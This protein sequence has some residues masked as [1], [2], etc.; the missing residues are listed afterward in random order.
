MPKTPTETASAK[1]SLFS[2]DG[3]DRLVRATDA[4]GN[5]SQTTYDVAGNA[6]RV[7][8]WGHPPN[9]PGAPNVL[10][11]HRSLLHDELGRVF[12][13]DVPLFVSQGFT[14]ARPPLLQDHDN[15]GFVTTRMDYDAL[16]RVTSLVED[17]LQTSRRVYDG[18]GRVIETM[19]QV[20]NRRR[21]TYDRNSNAIRSEG[22][23][24]S[25]EGL[26]P[27]EVFT[28][29]YVYDQLD[30]LVR[31]TDNAGQTTRFSYDSRNLLV[32]RS[33]P[34]GPLTSDPLNLFPGQINDGG[35]TYSFFHDG[36]G[37]RIRQVS[38]LR[39]GGTGV[40]A[41]DTSNPHNPDGQITLGY[42][43]DGNSR[44]VGIVDDKGNRTSFG[45]DALDRKTSHTFADGKSYD[46]V[47]DRDDNLRTI[48]DPNG[49]VAT[50]VFDVLNR[51]METTIQRGPG[52]IG[53]TRETFAYDG[54]S[55]LVR[56]TDD[57]G[58]AALSQHVVENVYDS[59][60]RLLEERQ[61][62]KAIS[63]R[64]TGDGKRT[65]ITY[66]GG[67]VISRTFDPIDRIKQIQDGN[68]VLA[69]TDWI[70]PGMRELRRINGNGT[71]L[72]FLNDAGSQDVGY[73]AVK[74]L[75]KLRVLSAGGVP[76]VD[77]DYA[78]NR[79]SQRTA[80]RRHDDFG[81][82]DRYTYDSSY[83]VV[84]STYDQDGLPDATPRDLSAI[85]YGYDGV[86][87]RREVTGQKAAGP[88]AEN[89]TVNEVNEYT[90]VA[91]I[92]QVNDDSGNL[93][94]DGTRLFSYDYRNRLASVRNKA[95][96][97]PIA[98]Y[99]YLP[100]GRRARKTV[101]SQT[102]LLAW[103]KGRSTSSGTASRKSRNRTPHQEPPTPRSSGLPFTLMSWFSSK[104][105]LAA[106]THIRMRDVAWLASRTRPGP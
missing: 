88:F 46:Y 3:F 62:G 75:V 5:E 82:T 31:A 95:T 1:R 74:R 24:V 72:T 96:G 86:G 13:T 2:Y 66:P 18:V 23:E 71:Q 8:A 27:N 105:A 92:P 12:Q 91:A 16:S 106:S 104:T 38:D 76:I 40:G 42:V 98:A 29:H 102:E 99:E 51:L 17:D 67:R 25:P 81:L 20:G 90:S 56:A 6:I 19:D 68:T 28:T 4:L 57:N 84:A 41:L 78:Y 22:I 55:R 49:S 35:N 39:I 65:Q 54:L 9:N 11:A 21:T 100:D 47:Y 79:A 69:A 89:Y 77:R 48:T 34:E 45:Y 30:R 36:L 94:D 101:Y 37:R 32:H 63:S 83:R 85:A 97:N 73:D 59:L 26:V 53:T 61:D 80:E 14:P 93:T 33:D 43:F 70:G 44:A 10:L 64:Y 50:R 52:V 60:G 103:S 87:N 7:Q 58:D 15:N